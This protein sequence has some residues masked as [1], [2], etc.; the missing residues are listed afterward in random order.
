M[1]PHIL[2]SVV[3][4]VHLA[5]YSSIKPGGIHRLRLDE[6]AYKMMSSC[7]ST[8]EYIM[9]AIELG[10]RVRRGELAATGINLGGLYAKA[11]REAYRWLGRGVY[12]DIII[13]SLTNALILS[14]TEVES[15][16]EDLGSVKRARSIFIDGSQWRDVRELMNALKTIGAEQMVTHL[17]E[18]GLTY[19]HALTESTGLTEV[20]NT[21]S[22]KWP[23]FITV[24]PRDDTVFNLVRKLMEYNREYSDFNSAIVR[25]YLEI[26]KPRL[27]DWAL[28]YVEE[29]LNHKL[30][31]TRE[32]SKIL[33]N[34][35][36]K[37]RKEG[38]TYDQYIPLLAAVLQLAVYD[39][40]RPHY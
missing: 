4:G 29:A 5:V 28:K 36:L 37:L 15:V 25:L 6:E 2:R 16:L 21:L 32:G 30:M 8:I 10:E 40:F 9:K 27:P 31:D 14:Y 17:Q 11:L 26:I 22:S 1:Y 23:G 18:V 35:D 24:N 39:G 34:L 38:F 13:P 33:F 19:T 7:T 12:P 3:E 20:F